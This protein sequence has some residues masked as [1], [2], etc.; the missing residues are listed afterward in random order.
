[1][2]I[3]ID[4]PSASGKGTLTK[5]LAKKIG[6]KYLNTGKL[7]RVV[8]FSI[9]QSSDIT[10]QAIQNSANFLDLLEKF[11]ENT[12]IFSQEN[13][14]LTSQISSIPKVRQ[15]LFQFQVDFANSSVPVILEGRDIGT[16]ILPNADFKFFITATPEE[17]ASRRLKQFNQES[18]NFEEIL[19]AIIKRDEMDSMRGNSPLKPSVDSIIIDT[20]GFSIEESLNTILREIKWQM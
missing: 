10:A 1:M 15:N 18:K 7:Y 19:N 14:E 2:K 20:T 6:A 12:A 5:L 17:R 9:N 13:G 8:A 3:A 11:G 16:H 4:G